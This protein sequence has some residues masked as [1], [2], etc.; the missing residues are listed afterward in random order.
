MNKVPRGNY[1]NHTGYVVLPLASMKNTLNTVVLYYWYY[2]YII[3]M[4]CYIQLVENTV[5][6]YNTIGAHLMAS[7]REF[8]ILASNDFHDFGSSA[9]TYNASTSSDHLYFFSILLAFLYTSPLPLYTLPPVLVLVRSQVALVPATSPTA[10]P[11]TTLVT[12]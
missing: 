9:N 8:M 12:L 11:A 2:T 7:M 3:W 1:C 10:V 4:K 6:V 5:H